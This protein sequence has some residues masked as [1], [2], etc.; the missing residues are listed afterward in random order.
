LGISF[1]LYV[2]NNL[3]GKFFLGDSGAQTIG[4]LLASF[5]MLYNPLNRNPESSWIVPIMLLGVPI[6]DT[7]LVVLSR[8][9]RSQSVGSGRRD[10]TYHR[11]IA[12]GMSPRYAVLVVHLVAFLIS[13]LAFL[14]LYLA[15]W[16]ALVFFI[17]TILCGISLLIWLERKPTLDD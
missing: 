3:A 2:W 10:H 12:I 5:G 16:L 4:F 6:F 14:T 15:A 8:L 11:L 1:G 9:R 13:C 7:T 17:A